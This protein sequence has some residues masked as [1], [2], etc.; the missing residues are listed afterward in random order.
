[1]IQNIFWAETTDCCLPIT[2]SCSFQGLNSQ[3]ASSDHNHSKKRCYYLDQMDSERTV[4]QSCWET[5]MWKFIGLSLKDDL[6]W[7]LKTA[8]FSSMITLYNH[9][10][11]CLSLGFNITGNIRYDFLCFH[12]WKRTLIY[13]LTQ[14][15]LVNVKHW[16][17]I[18]DWSL[19][20]CV[21][22]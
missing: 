3:Q 2:C 13:F 10:L 20:S 17:M 21:Q 18:G 7:Y 22:I 4:M 11:P 8:T 6:S 14:C 19:S 5:Q 12:Y 16:L 1:M 9:K 15:N